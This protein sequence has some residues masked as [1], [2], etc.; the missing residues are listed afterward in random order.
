MTHTNTATAVRTWNGPRTKA[1]ITVTLADGRTL[2]A[3][4]NRAARAAAVILTRWEWTGKPL[5]L[6]GLRA[7]AHAA[8]V[9][10]DRLARQTSMR[11][12]GM[13]MAVTPAAEAYAIEI[14][15]AWR[16]G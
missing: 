7:D 4:G 13:R 8:R 16:D 5:A 12:H 1:T 2:T 9:E 10:A 3:G 15:E 6:Y 11:H 14:T